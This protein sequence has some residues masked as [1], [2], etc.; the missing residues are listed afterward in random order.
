MYTNFEQIFSGN[1]DSND[2]LEESSL[3]INFEG[4]YNAL[5]SNGDYNFAI[6]AFDILKINECSLVSTNLMYLM[7]HAHMR[8]VNVALMKEN[9]KKYESDDYIQSKLKYTIE[10]LEGMES[11]F[12]TDVK[13]YYKKMKQ[14]ESNYKLFKND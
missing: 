9:M 11:S 6:S 13:E 10:E 12:D 4:M 7:I 3:P 5:K 8:K 1:D 2:V 14:L